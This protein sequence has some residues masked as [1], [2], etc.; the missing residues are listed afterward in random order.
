[1][2]SFYVIMKIAKPTTN[3]KIFGAMGLYLKFTQKCKCCTV[4][5]ASCIFRKA[6]DILKIHASEDQ[7][8]K[9]SYFWI[10]NTLSITTTIGRAHQHISMTKNLWNFYNLSG[11]R[12][13]CAIMMK[14]FVIVI[15]KNPFHRIHWLWCFVIDNVILTKK[16]L[17]FKLRCWRRAWFW[18]ENKLEEVLPI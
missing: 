1:M 17:D 12:R 13:W 3:L 5:T 8:L 10:K 14:N 2:N 7:A 18:K 15:Y 4:R 9:S 11:K 6:I 16:I